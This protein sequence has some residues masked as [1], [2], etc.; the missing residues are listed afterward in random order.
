M[1]SKRPPF[2]T[3]FDF[4]SQLNFELRRVCHAMSYNS[5]HL[6]QALIVD[7]KHELIVDMMNKIT[8]FISPGLGSGDGEVSALY[9]LE[10][11]ASGRFNNVSR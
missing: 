3:S 8:T 5:N 9:F 7:L 6:Q 1:R 11:S 10:Y 4:H 2:L